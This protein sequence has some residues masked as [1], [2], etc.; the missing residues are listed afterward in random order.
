MKTNVELLKM[1]PWLR[2]RDEW[3]DEVIEQIEGR[4]MTMLYELPDIWLKKFVE[5]ML[6]D[7]QEI[8]VRYDIVDTYRVREARERYGELLWKDNLW[9]FNEKIRD[10][11]NVWYDMW[12]TVSTLIPIDQEEGAEA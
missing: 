1:Y 8:L 11:L 4:E 10:E 12:S 2:P 5:E 6:I 7:L 3:T 9:M